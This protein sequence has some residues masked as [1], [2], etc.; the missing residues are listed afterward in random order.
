MFESAKR[1]GWR[2]GTKLQAALVASNALSSIQNNLQ[3][4]SALMQG[5][6]IIQTKAATT[7]ETIKTAAQGRGVIVTKAATIAQAAFNAVA[8]ANPLC[9]ACYGLCDGRRGFVCLCQG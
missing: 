7:A 1:I 8:K 2:L 5:I 9:S 3:K 6:G 4:Q